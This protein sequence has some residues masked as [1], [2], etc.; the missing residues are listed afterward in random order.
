MTGLWRWCLIALCLAGE[1]RADEVRLAVAANFLPVAESL[2]A[3]FEAATGHEVVLG[4]GSS[5]KLFAQIMAGAPWE[6]FLSA[7][8]E[9]PAALEAAGRAVA[10][11]PYAFGRLALVGPPGSL[12]EPRSALAGEGRVAIADPRVAPYGAAALEALA[13][14]GYDVATLPLVRADNLG[15]AASF[16]ATGNARFAVLAQSHVAPL[17]AL[18]SLDAWPVPAAAHAPIRQE[19][20]LVAGAGEAARAFYA[21]LGSPEARAAIAAAGYGVPQ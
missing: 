10:R 18:R 9:R 21:H 20:A 2:A 4:H 6:V 3:D 11:K 16:F 13:W 17:R 7:D 15:A 8:D 14:L 5:G 19:A 1:V 12:A